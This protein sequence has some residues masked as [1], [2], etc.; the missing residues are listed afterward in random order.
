MTLLA[1]GYH[2][3]AAEPPA[4]PR[5]IFPVTVDGLGAQ[6][7]L[8]GRSFEFVSRDELLAAVAGEVPLP[9]RACVVTFDD[10]LRCQLEL[11]LPVL[12]RLGVPAIFFVAGKPL[13]EE[14][15]LYVH[16]VHALRERVPDAELLALAGAADVP[17]DVAQEHY[18]YD[19]PDAAR[20]K[21]LLNMR[22][23]L[24]E[25]EQVVGAAFAEVFPDEAAFARELYMS[26]EDVAELERGHAAVGAHS[27]AHEPLARLDGDALDDDLQAVAAL[28]EEVTGAR[29]RALSYPHGTPSTVDLR[30][31]RRAEAAGFRVAFTMERALNRTLEEPLLLGRLDANDA[32]GGKRPRL[33]LAAGEP[34]VDDG[35]SLARERYVEERA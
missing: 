23:P 22:L 27:Y 25:R 34:V 24:D 33:R 30:V 4:E 12:E 16:K 2:Y 11:A 6:L 32:P 9:A 19:E 18:R 8:V 17:V 1:V 28:L 7:E 26:R 14:L 29:P 5:A 15:V 31:A 10:G 21:Y 13:A 20:L 3:V 35:V